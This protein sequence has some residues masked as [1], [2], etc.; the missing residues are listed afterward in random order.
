MPRPSQGKSHMHSRASFAREFMRRA[1][2]R[3]YRPGSHINFYVFSEGILLFLPRTS[4]KMSIRIMPTYS[5]GCWAVPR[6]PASPTTPIAK[7][8]SR[9][10][11]QL[12]YVLALICYT[13]YPDAKPARPTER[14][15]KNCTKP[16]YKGRF[17]FRSFA[18]RTETTK[19]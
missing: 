9:K 8:K 6:T 5:F 12:S 3:P 4:A 17:C 13:T 16:V 15:V 1:T 10:K 7:L 14:P 18:T 2:I 11:G 19:P